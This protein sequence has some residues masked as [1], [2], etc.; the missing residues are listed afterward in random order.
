MGIFLTGALVADVDNSHGPDVR[1]AHGAAASAAERGPQCQ[2]RSDRAKGWD[3]PTA[4][5]LLADTADS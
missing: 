1:V 2:D 4:I 3:P 5:T